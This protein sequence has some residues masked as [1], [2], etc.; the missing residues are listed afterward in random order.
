MLML[1]ATEILSFCVWPNITDAEFE[2]LGYTREQTQFMYGLDIECDVV[3]LRMKKM[4]LQRGDLINYLKYVEVYEP[5]KVK[6][7]TEY[8]YDESMKT[9]RKTDETQT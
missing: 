4:G 8:M 9:I 2:E 5:S 6:I 1:N 3:K 7:L